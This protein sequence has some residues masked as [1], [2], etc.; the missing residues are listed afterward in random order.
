M[1]DLSVFFKKFKQN[2]MF[3]SNLRVLRKN[4]VSTHGE[5]VF[6]PDSIAPLF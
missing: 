1:S 4:E 6:A 3:K 2:I 5:R